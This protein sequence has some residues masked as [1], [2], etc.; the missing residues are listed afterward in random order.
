MQRFF[1]ASVLLFIFSG[2]KAQSS[3]YIL[4]IINIVPLGNVDYGSSQM[5]VVSPDGNSNSNTITDFFLDPVAHEK[6]IN[7]QLNLIANLGYKITSTVT[8]SYGGVN[9]KFYI[10]T[11]YTLSK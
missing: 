9:M 8:N 2:I 4:T 6:E 7:D 11:R 3:N 10:W 1:L 5:I